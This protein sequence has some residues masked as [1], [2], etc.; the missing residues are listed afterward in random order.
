M[1][2]IRSFRTLIDRKYSLIQLSISRRSIGDNI[3]YCLSC[4]GVLHCVIEK[5]MYMIY[6]DTIKSKRI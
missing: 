5:N 3:L 2:I 1:F 6:N 4:F